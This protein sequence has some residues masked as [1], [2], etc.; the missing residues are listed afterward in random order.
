MPGNATY[1]L[2]AR[3]DSQSLVIEGFIDVDLE[4]AQGRIDSHL[5]LHDAARQLRAVHTTDSRIYHAERVGKCII[6]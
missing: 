4:K 2:L 6:F 5:Q 3:R 1:Q